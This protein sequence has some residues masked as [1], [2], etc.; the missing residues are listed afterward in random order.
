MRLPVPTEPTKDE[1]RIVELQLGFATRLRQSQY[2]IVE[3]TKTT[4]V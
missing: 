3:K 4:G 1:K 2:Y